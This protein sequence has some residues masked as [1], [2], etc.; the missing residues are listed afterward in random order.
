M[1]LT[2]GP[3]SE[4][5]GQKTT[6]A[7]GFYRR[8]I[9]PLP[10]PLRC[11]INFLV[12]CSLLYLFLLGLNLMGDAFKGLSGKGAG[13]LLASVSNP[14][15]AISIGVLAT[16]LLQSSSTTTS[17]IV[18]M[19][20][21]DIITV[22][23]AIPMAMGANIGTSVTNTIVAHGHILDMKEFKRGFQGAT[24]HD[25][26][27]LLTVA[28]LLPVEIITQACGMGLLLA[29]SDG[30]ADALVGASAS[31]F[32]SP[33]KVIVGPLSKLFISVDKNIIK[34]I[35]KGCVACSK[36]CVAESDCCKDDSRKD[37]AGEKIK[38][39]VPRDEW[40]Q[41]YEEGRILKGGFAKDIGDVG[42][43][44]IVLILSL[45]FLC[46]A[47]YGIVRVLHYLVLSSGRVE[48]AD[49]TEAPFVRY[50]RKVLRLNQYLSILFG[51]IMTI[52]VQSSSITTSALTPLV[53]LGI[54]SV[55]DML[56]LTLGA[57]LGTTCTAFLASI[58]TEKKNAIQIALCHLTF[59]IFGVLIWFPVPLMRKV[60]LAMA[61]LLGE[62]SMWYKWF[63][64]FYILLC[65]VICPLLLMAFSFVID[66][67]PGGIVLNI[68][69]D[70]LL[71]VFVLALVYK[72]DWVAGKFK[73]QAK[74][75]DKTTE[76]DVTK[77][78]METSEKS[79]IEGET[80][81]AT[82]QEEVA[83]TVPV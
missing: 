5:D 13:E 72:I 82:K 79:A 70:L 26:F 75:D 51:M 62:R 36:K 29:I 76:T 47:L 40:R 21:A 50:T 73:L 6:R 54:I 60:P 67:G 46:V 71:I 32:T 15:A 74:K 77:A 55:E 17:I 80:D 18:T 41:I 3:E 39:C 19:V 37:K 58:V 64:S 45:I 68:V 12:I 61:G 24:V 56:P 63:G 34:G 66:L 14:M 31:T 48:N 20:G 22:E 35:A 7:K 57:N 1:S 2:D 44:V 23:N 81:T 49:G 10:L 78:G 59:N 53:A 65:F 33:V 25:A 9:G 27:N 16:V 4:N 28:I 43:S 42:G 69:L 30:I 83:V 11:L 52:L 38:R 8:F